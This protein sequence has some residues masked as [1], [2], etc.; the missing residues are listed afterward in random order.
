MGQKRAQLGLACDWKEAFPNAPWCW[1]I[2][3]H[4][5]EKSSSLVGKYTSTMV[6]RWVSRWATEIRVLCS[7][8]LWSQC[9][10]PWD[11]G[12]TTAAT[13]SDL[14][15]RRAH[16]GMKRSKQAKSMCFWWRLHNLK[17]NVNQNQSD[18]LCNMMILM[19]NS[20]LQVIFPARKL[21]LFHGFSSS[22][23]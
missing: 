8:S 4:F 11:S 20:I 1:N 21:H 13:Y 3:Q 9:Q 10:Q 7:T 19:N 6:R 16:W 17:T 23:C 18:L 12:E 15:F 5:P 22:L 2:Y 14:P